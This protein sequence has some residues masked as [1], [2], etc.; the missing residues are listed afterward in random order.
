MRI[1]RIILALSLIILPQSEIFAVAIP[2]KYTEAGKYFGYGC[3]CAGLEFLFAR[4]NAYLP[5]TKLGNAAWECYNKNTLLGDLGAIMC[6]GGSAGAC[7]L[8]SAPAIFS[9]YCFAKSI[10]TVV[11]KDE[12]EQIKKNSKQE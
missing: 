12:D 9:V 1:R 10:K 5:S 2:K 7:L 11:S 3:L 4:R 6:A 8:A